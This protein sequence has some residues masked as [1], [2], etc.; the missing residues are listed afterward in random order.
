M[1]VRR[2][3][4]WNELRKIIV[5]QGDVPHDDIASL[6]RADEVDKLVAALLNDTSA[7]QA[8]EARAGRMLQA[9]DEATRGALAHHH[10]QSRLVRAVVLC[11]LIDDYRD[12]CGKEVDLIQSID[13]ADAREVL[14][15]R[16]KLAP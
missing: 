10:R 12:L 1:H 8:P 16:P 15:A 6:A 13:P 3:E 4:I 11:N 9:V 14:F 5:A 7:H 2:W